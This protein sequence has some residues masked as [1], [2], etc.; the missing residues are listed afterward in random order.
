MPS[1]DSHGLNFLRLRIQAAENQFGRG[2]LMIRRD[3]NNRVWEG[4]NEPRLVE[5]KGVN[6]VGTEFK[7]SFYRRP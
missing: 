5:I 2:T 6:K 1:G 7:Q 3:A 4:K